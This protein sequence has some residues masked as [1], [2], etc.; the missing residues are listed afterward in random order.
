MSCLTPLLSVCG[1]I[2][3]LH[4]EAL[5]TV[6][7]D[8]SGSEIMKRHVSK[9][10]ESPSFFVFSSLKESTGCNDSF[11]WIYW[12]LFFSKWKRNKR[13]TIPIPIPIPM[14]GFQ[15]KH[16]LGFLLGQGALSPHF[17]L[18][19]LLFEL[20]IAEDPNPNFICLCNNFLSYIVINTL[21]KNV[22]FF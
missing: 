12:I 11:R 14:Y 1:K 16:Y 4:F 8:D 5:M 2:L 13:I 7:A 19:P 22:S 10:W 17:F 15:E 9:E 21:P 18:F 3:L 6:N 20:E